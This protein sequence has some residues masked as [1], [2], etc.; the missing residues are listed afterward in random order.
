MIER[1]LRYCPLCQH[2]GP[3]TSCPRDGAPTLP[4]SEVA[5]GGDFTGQ[6]INGKYQIIERLGTG[7]MGSVWIARQLSMGQ[8]VAVKILTAGGAPELRAVERFYAE[9]RACSRLSHPNIIRVTDF[10][11]TE[12]GLPFMVMELLRGSDLSAAL[13]TD[14]H[15]PMYRA[16]RIARQVC[17]A[18]GEAHAQG[19]IHRDLKPSN[20]FLLRSQLKTDYVKV[21]DFGI[22]KNL[23]DA[24]GLTGTGLVIGTPRYM[25][26]EQ[27][28]GN[29]V[30]P[31][32]DLY[33][34]G[35]ILFEMLVGQTPFQGD[36]ASALMMA[37]VKTPPPPLP[38]THDG[39][40]VPEELHALVSSLLAKRPADRPPDAA[41][42]HATLVSLEA[43]LPPPA[44]LRRAT[45][46]PTAALPAPPEA[47]RVDEPDPPPFDLPPAP[48]DPELE[49]TPR[50]PRTSVTTN[51]TGRSAGPPTRPTRPPQGRPRDPRSGPPTRPGQHRTPA[52]RRKDSTRLLVIA[53]VSAVGIMTLLVI[54][55]VYVL[56]SSGGQRTADAD[57]P[58]PRLAM[59]E[60]YGEA[61]G[62]ADEGE[63]EAL[64][65]DAPPVGSTVDV[66]ERPPAPADIGTTP[67]APPPLPAPPRGMVAVA[68]G[69]Y[70]VGCQ[71]GDEGCL[72][73]ELPGHEAELGAFAILRTEVR[74]ADYDECVANGKCP[75]A[76]TDE[77][78]NWQ[79]AGREDHPINC[80]T[81]HGADAYCTW[82]GWRLPTEVEWEAAAR[83]RDGNRYPWGQD[84][85]SCDR[86][87][88][89]GAKPGCGKGTTWPVGA[90]EKD[91]SWC[92]AVDLGGS[93]REWVDA[94][95]GPYPM[96]KADTHVKGKVNR[97]GSFEMESEQMSRTHTRLADP[98]DQQL[99]DL[100]F[101]CAVDL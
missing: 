36:T 19:I 46:P 14:G 7:G 51:A 4:L 18:L 52:N 48:P 64:P 96:G 45:T 65:D 66:H 15:L 31:Q 57:R 78:C 73:D 75:E 74:M 88:M 55:A 92:G 68:S 53:L 22:S 35:I 100:G 37:Q 56:R 47:A 17:E 72:F 39:C 34:L 26:P 1:P 25:S 40:A 60:G 23:A 29:Q 33:A 43:L 81:W 8:D 44:T 95:Y 84:P 89:A 54:A 99:P 16:V 21:I 94:N 83:G 98:P 10:G 80:V 50:G 58:E 20:V 2:R 61:D 59:S 49:P 70:P 101:R 93:V 30:G 63:D 13:R 24:S 71:T 90:R 27:I 32:A 97:G 85:P 86:T 79:T 6:V 87:I 69:A 77:G 76:G 28:R 41:D 9:A 62:P 82:K 12:S 67:E 5:P 42:V 91:R 38:R 3:E 11:A